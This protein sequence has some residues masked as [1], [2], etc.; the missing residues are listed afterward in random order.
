M[1]VTV[2]WELIPANTDSLKLCQQRPFKERGPCGGR[3]VG[4]ACRPKTCMPKYH[5]IDSFVIFVRSI[6][7]FRPIRV[8]TSDMLESRE[9]E[10]IFGL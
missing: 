1:A 10:D 7:V 8:L 6:H 5:F 4:P 3:L 9:E 2:V